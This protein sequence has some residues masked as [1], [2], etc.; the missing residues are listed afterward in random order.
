MRA[1]ISVLYAY[2]YM[3]VPGN[4]LR[5]ASYTLIIFFEK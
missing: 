4:D 3:N 2:V 1:C 5:V